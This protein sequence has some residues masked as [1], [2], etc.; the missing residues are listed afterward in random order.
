MTSRRAQH[1]T[2]GLNRAVHVRLLAPGHVRQRLLGSGID[3]FKR[4][5]I[6]GVT[7]GTVNK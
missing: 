6:G 2:C 7:I 3:G 4:G 1:L 5:I